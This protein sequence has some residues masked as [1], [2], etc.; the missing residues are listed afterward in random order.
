VTAAGLIGG[1]RG[2]YVGDMDVKPS[3]LD[4]LKALFSDRVSDKGLGKK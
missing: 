3:F 4:C 1:G 2:L